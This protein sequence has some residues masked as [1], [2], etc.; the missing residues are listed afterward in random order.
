MLHVWYQ[1]FVFCDDFFFVILIIDLVGNRS[2]ACY[3]WVSYLLK[4]SGILHKWVV[5]VVSEPF[6]LSTNTQTHTHNTR[7]TG[8]PPCTFISVTVRSLA[9]YPIPHLKTILIV[10]STVSMNP[11]T[12]KWEATKNTQTNK[13]T[14][15]SPSHT[16]HLT[17]WEI[18]QVN[19][20]TLNVLYD[21]YDNSILARFVSIGINPNMRAHTTN[22]SWCVSLH[23]CF[24]FVFS[25]P[26]TN[27]HRAYQSGYMQKANH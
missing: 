1:S 21:M 10:T 24:L 3:V 8:T 13:L 5:T 12:G 15:K 2:L 6:P 23:S 20:L 9:P 25:G 26:V 19:Q 11:R 16:Q 17:Q 4:R 22:T 18:T 7:K 14:R 27:K